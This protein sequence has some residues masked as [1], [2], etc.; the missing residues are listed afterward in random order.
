MVPF[1]R[2][3]SQAEYRARLTRLTSRRVWSKITF[4][5]TECWLWHGSR[6]KSG[7]GELT[8]GSR[9]DCSRKTVLIHRFIFE[10]L[11]GTI[12]RHLQIDHRCEVKLCVNPEHLRTVTHKFNTLRSDTASGRN[13]RKTLC[14]RG[15]PYDS[16]RRRNG[17]RRCSICH[18]AQAKARHH[19]I[20]PTLGTRCNLAKTHCPRGHPYDKVN[21]KGSRFCSICHNAKSLE[22]YHHKRGLS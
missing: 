20:D 15:H 17:S 14:P 4:E 9:R 6:M 12:P 8:V 2:P 19:K 18:A 3:P 7:Y 21:K 1:E 16:I 11:V 13:S 22:A 10:A 5:P